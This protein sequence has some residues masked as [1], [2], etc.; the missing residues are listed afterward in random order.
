MVNHE[1]MKQ[2]IE[3][4]W[5]YYR[6]HFIVAIVALLIIVATVSE[7]IQQKD[8]LLSVIMLNTTTSLT[9]TTGTGFEEF[10]QK[11][12][13]EY[14]DGALEM[15]RDLYFYG[16]ESTSYEDYENYE[17]LLALLLGGKCEVFMGTGDV[18]LEFVNQG[19]FVDLSEALSDE[20]LDMYEGQII[21]SEDMGELDPYPCVIELSDNQWL[22]ENNYY[23]EKC[24]FGILKSADTPEVAA[25][26][27]DFLLNYKRNSAK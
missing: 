27:A 15:K 2:R 1:K 11:Y 25:D 7:S 9:D 4:L 23:N 3:Y 8:P 22:K 6:W 5:D 10:F 16:K 13:Y 18:Y 17:I 14:F 19:Y 26:F 21:Y 20:L 24:Y 12:G